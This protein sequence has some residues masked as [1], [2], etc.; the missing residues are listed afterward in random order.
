MVTGVPPASSRRC[1]FEQSYVRVRSGQRQRSLM[2]PQCTHIQLM[3]F[4]GAYRLSTRA[5]GGTCRVR[6]DEKRRQSRC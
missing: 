1:S 3:S 6:I 4:L 5:L 2:P